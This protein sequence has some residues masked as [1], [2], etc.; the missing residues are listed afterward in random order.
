[1]DT[2]RTLLEA[3]SLFTLFIA[4]ALG[5][6]VGEIGIKGVSPGSGAVLFVG[7]A[8][9]GFA[10][11]LQRQRCSARSGSCSFCTASASSTATSS[12]GD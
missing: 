7:L 4:V 9:G 3:Q 10:P 5:Y 1:M 12:S 6:V 8:I 2:L 11:S